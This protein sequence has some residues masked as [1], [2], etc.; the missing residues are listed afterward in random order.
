MIAHPQ[1]SV[2]LE[3]DGQRIFAGAGPLTGD[4]TGPQWGLR[5]PGLPDL[6]RTIADQHESAITTGP[7]PTVWLEDSTATNAP[8]R[9]PLSEDGRYRG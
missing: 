8:S 2:I 3:F 6:L 5:I 4:I 7:D 1:V 9:L